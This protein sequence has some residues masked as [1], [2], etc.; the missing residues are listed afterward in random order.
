M[1]T[2][3]SGELKFSDLNTTFGNDNSELKFSEY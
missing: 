3:T 2:P 1:S